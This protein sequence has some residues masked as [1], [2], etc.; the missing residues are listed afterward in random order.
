MKQWYVVH[1]HALG[2]TK[3]L[4]HL[5][6]QRFETFL[7]MYKK[8]R[9]HARTVDVVARPLFP[10]YLFVALDL[11]IDKW[12]SVQ[13]TIGVSHL[14]CHGEQPATVPKGMV[15]SLRLRED[16][17]GYCALGD[18]REFKKGQFVE[19]SDGPFS[20][21][22]GVFDTVNDAERV[23]ILLNLMGRE[24]RVQVPVQVVKAC[25]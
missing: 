19:I 12:W 22:T 17:D 14:I 11:S 2:E 9:R 5:R 7:P 23:Y 18:I 6:R 21:F 15:D 13:S 8:T 10:R 1:T 25:A 4:F 3:A 20:A 24:V 16:A